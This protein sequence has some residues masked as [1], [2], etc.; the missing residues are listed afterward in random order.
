MVRQER[1]QALRTEKKTKTV[2]KKK[3]KTPFRAI[4][5]SVRSIAIEKREKKKTEETRNKREKT[6]KGKKEK[7]GKKERVRGRKGMWLSHTS[8]NAYSTVRTCALH[9]YIYICHC[10]RERKRGGEKGRTARYVGD[11][12]GQV[13]PQETLPSFSPPIPPSLLFSLSLSLSLLTAVGSRSLSFRLTPS[14]AYN[15]KPSASSCR[16]A[17]RSPCFPRLTGSRMCVVRFLLSQRV[18]VSSRSFSP[19]ATCRI[20]CI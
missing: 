19:H 7:E 18:L 10:T 2:T 11:V 6:R 15:L 1:V 12:C 20:R 3:R 9:M 4:Q 5:S 17:R 14:L 13:I 8:T 16:V